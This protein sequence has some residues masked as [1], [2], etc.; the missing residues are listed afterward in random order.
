MKVILFTPIDHRHRFTT[1]CRHSSGGVP[2]GAAAG[3]AICRNEGDGSFYLFG[4]DERWHSISDTWHETPE[5]AK[6]QAEFEYE[7]I[8]KTWQAIDQTA[9]RGG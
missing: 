3:L 5:G 6:D 1:S 2:F 8:T 4:C 9:G 7:G